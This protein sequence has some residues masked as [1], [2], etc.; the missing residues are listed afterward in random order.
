MLYSQF[1]NRPTTEEFW[2]LSRESVENP[3]KAIYR[4]FDTYGLANMEE[5][6]WQ[7]FRLTMSSEEVNEWTE[8]QRANC[9]HFYELLFDLLKANYALYLKMRNEPGRG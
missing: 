2:F 5:R 6:L 7:M 4:F 3:Q 1:V 9:F 8:V